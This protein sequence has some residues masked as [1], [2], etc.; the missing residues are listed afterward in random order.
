MS[1]VKPVA[2]LFAGLLVIFSLCLSAPLAVSLWQQDGLWLDYAGSLLGGCAIGGVVFYK[3]R[4]HR[5][6]LQ[7]RHGVLLVTC[8][9]LLLPLFAS[10]PI[11]LA[12]RQV[13]QDPGFAGAFFEGVSGLTTSG[14]TVLSSLQSLPLSLNLWRTFMQWLGG[15]GILI[16]AVAILPMLGVGGSQ[17]F[18]A[19]VAGPIKDTK[20]TPRI[21][22]TAKG[23]WSVYLGLSL[24][25]FVAFWAG[26]MDAADA[27]MHMFTTVS[28]GGLSPHDTSFGYF[29][30]PLLEAIAV[31]FMLIASCNFALYFVAVRKRSLRGAW[32]NAELRATLLV[33]VGSGLLVSLFLWSKNTYAFADA[34]RFGMFNTISLATTTGFATT[35]YLS[36]PMFAPLLMLLLSGVASSAGSTGGGVKM[37]RV[38][39][40][41]QQAA[42]ELT[43]LVHPTVINPVRLNHN[44]VE[45][46]VIFSVL[47]FMM[48][49]IITIVLLGLVLVFT[50]LDLVTAFSAVIASINCTGPGLG[51]VGPSSTYAVMNSFQLTVCSF[52][53]LLGRLEIL[54]M[55]VLL[56]PSFWRR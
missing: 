8:V 3:L 47:A 27:L 31:G 42:R 36:W 19:E 10:V 37:L 18:K 54:S 5:Q 39:I 40:L 35:D 32:R 44:I 30:S 26:G 25:C 51:L 41:V 55:M 1:D 22:H 14:A 4:R 52:A 23:L 46:K 7:P 11:W 50:D 9:W 49:Y 2:R 34:L 6:E 56:M 13:G 21:T 15:M 12:L 38:L 45:S 28:L 16:L 33:L 29:D 53:M 48:F 43:R 17:V 20:L 24:A